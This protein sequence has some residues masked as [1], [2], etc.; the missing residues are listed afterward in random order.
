MIIGEYNLV[1]EDKVNRVIKGMPLR[2]GQLVGGIGEFAYKHPTQE[3]E[4][5]DKDGNKKKVLKVIE[6]KG[7]AKEE[8]E[9]KQ[10][11]EWEQK[12]LVGY[13]RLGGLI[14]KNGLKVKNGTLGKVVY[15]AK[16]EGNLLEVTE[17]EAKALETAQKKVAEVKEKKAT[18]KR[19]RAIEE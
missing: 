2:Q 10:K 16:L 3:V 4:E 7:K 9:Q 12:V 11:A 1:N 8:E 18:K 19:K 15:E 17:E 5:E 14:T 6:L 13:D